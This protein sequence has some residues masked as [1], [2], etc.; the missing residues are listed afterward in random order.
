MGR[1]SAALASSV[2]SRILRICVCLLACA[3]ALE[4]CTGSS[5]ET[6]DLVPTPGEGGS[7]PAP[8]PGADAQILVAAPQTTPPQTTAPQQAAAQS[9]APLLVSGQAEGTA[10]T[11]AVVPSGAPT[12]TG[13]EVVSDAGDDATY[14]MGE[15]ISV[16]ITFS[17]AVDVTG[18][19]TLGIDMDPAHW[20]RE[21]ALY[22]SGSGSAA[23]TFAHT[24]V[25]PNYSSQGIAVLAYTLAL[26]DGT[27]QATVGG[28]DAELAHDGLSH[29]PDHKV[30]WWQSS[31][32][33]SGNRPPVFLGESQTMERAVPGVLFSLDLSKDDFIDFDGEPL[34]F[35]LSTSRDDIYAPGWLVYFDSTGRIFYQAKTGCALTG[36]APPSGDAYETVVTL[37]ATDPDGASAHATATFRT[38]P[39]EYVCPSLSGAAVDGETLTITLD[40]NAAPSAEQPAAWEFAV[41]VD[42]AVM[43][44]ASLGT[45]AV[46]VNGN[47][48]ELTLASPVS[49]GQTVAVSYTPGDNPIAAS[50]TGQSVTN[51]TP[52]PA[53]S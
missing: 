29:D 4:A 47:M 14:A 28:A 8:S 27:I 44:L 7:P 2:P 12:V 15:V 33:A 52:A 26:G 6:S 13:V 46:T 48:I 19:P 51:N 50:F 16:R 53:E 37:T 17:E 40:G 45:D 22:Q 24:V 25:E 18:V 42:G 5:P 23:L 21:N 36:L 35:T 32:D 49:A 3:V 31:P 38:D 20:G 34:T 10:P 39:T 9:T 43:S 30:D 41:Q 1:T 11:H